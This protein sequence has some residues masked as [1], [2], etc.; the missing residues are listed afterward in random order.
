VGGGFSDVKIRTPSKTVI[1]CPGEGFGKALDLKERGQ[2]GGCL[3]AAIFA[4]QNLI[5]TVF[6]QKYANK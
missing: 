6:F 4:G 2:K 3:R 5:K 1:S